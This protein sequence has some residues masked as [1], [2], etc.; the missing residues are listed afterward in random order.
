MIWDDHQGRCIGELSFRSQVSS[1]L[2]DS[3]IG[4]ALWLL[5]P[6]AIR[7]LRPFD[8]PSAARHPRPCFQVHSVRLRRDRIVVALEH[9]VLQ[10]VFHNEPLVS[11]GPVSFSFYMTCKVANADCRMAPESLL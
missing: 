2:G 6:L 10:H 11:D 7:V 5:L 1:A 8:L 9:K 4:Q 3:C